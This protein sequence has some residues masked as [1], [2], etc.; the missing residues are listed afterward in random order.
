MH[1]VSV[2]R[3]NDSNIFADETSPVTI[4]V[5]RMLPGIYPVVKAPPE[6]SYYIF[7]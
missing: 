4:T 5:R 3:L 6:P 7:A 2:L 1:S